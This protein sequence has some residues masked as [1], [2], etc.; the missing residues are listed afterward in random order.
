MCENYKH[1]EIRPQIEVVARVEK[2]VQPKIQWLITITPR[3][4][5]FLK[6]EQLSEVNLPTDSLADMVPNGEQVSDKFGSC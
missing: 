4:T 3:G 1:N 2:K 6:S 5:S